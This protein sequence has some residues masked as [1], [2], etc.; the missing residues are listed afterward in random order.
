ME[1]GYIVVCPPKTD[2][3]VTFPP[4]NW[5]NGSMSMDNRLCYIFEDFFL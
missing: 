2:Y 5:L 3:I 1:I 4:D